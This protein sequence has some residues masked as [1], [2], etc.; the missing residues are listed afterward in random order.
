ME[1]SEAA[2]ILNV[3]VEATADEVHKAFK[4][5]SKRHHPDVGGSQEAFIKLQ[6]A[7]DV[8]LGKD[9]P[10][11][12]MSQAIAEFMGAFQAILGRSNN[13]LAIDLIER[14]KG[15]LADQKIQLGKQIE[16][17]QLDLTQTEKILQKLECHSE[18]DFLGNMLAQHIEGAK[19]AILSTQAK[20]DNLSQAMKIAD[21]YKY[22]ADQPETNLGGGLW[23]NMSVFTV[24]T[25]G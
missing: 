1:K 6:L 22:N 2:K 9:A 11:P 21:F 17:I 25:G 8:L 24:N 16:N 12:A 20:I 13:P 5:R 14:T 15:L 19:Q 10:K 3:G 18:N 4:Y 23:N 7:H